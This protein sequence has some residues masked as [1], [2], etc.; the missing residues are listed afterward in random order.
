[1]FL[2][3]GQTYTFLSFSYLPP[4]LSFMW[5]KL[6][7]LAALSSYF[8][9]SNL[10]QTAP[11][12]ASLEFVENR[13]QWPAPVRY[14]ADIPGGRLFLEPGGL[15]YSLLAGV[16]HGHDA[17]SLPAADASI[18]AHALRVTFAGAAPQPTLRAE[19]QTSEIRNYL[20]G[21]DPKQWAPMPGQIPTAALCRNLAR[22]RGPLLRKPAAAAGVRLR[23]GRPRQ[24]GCHPASL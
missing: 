23:V 12:A 16:P 18:K 5:R 20:R 7:C 8:I 24:S 1:M 21:N 13:G 22:H 19:T 6:L 17:T 15:T 4:S 2:I 14:T 11:P 3:A 10:A 9:N